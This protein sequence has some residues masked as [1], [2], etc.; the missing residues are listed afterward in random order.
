MA[1]YTINQFSQLSGVSLN[2]L[3]TYVKAGLLK[4]AYKSHTNYCYYDNHNLM[5]LQQIT[6]LKFIGFSHEKIKAILH[7]STDIREFLRTQADILTEFSQHLSET[8][9]LLHSL[10]TQLEQDKEIDWEIQ[11]KIISVLQT[12]KSKQHD[13]YDLFLTK[14]ENKTFN[15]IAKTK[16]P[17]EWQDYNVRW[18][19][20]FEDI[21]A[22]LHIDPESEIGLEFARRWFD[23]VKEVYAGNEALGNKLWEGYKGGVTDST[24]PYNPEILAYM[25]KAKNKYKKIQDALE[26]AHE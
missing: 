13:W 12:K 3:R 16:T 5:Q 9:R 2:L 20:L 8:A 22:N 24:L 14:T 19:K 23:L 26:I 1:K 7:K 4:P 6:T 21:S 17:E 10:I 25:A 18:A 15:A 11:T